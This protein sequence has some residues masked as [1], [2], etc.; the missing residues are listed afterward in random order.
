MSLYPRAFFWACRISWR[1]FQGVLWLKYP[2]K[3]E[4]IQGHLGKTQE[5]SKGDVDPLQGQLCFIYE[6]Q[7]GAESVSGVAEM[8]IVRYFIVLFNLLFMSFSIRYVIVQSISIYCLPM[9]IIYCSRV[10]LTFGKWSVFRYLQ[11]KKY[12][13]NIHCPWYFLANLLRSQCDVTRIGGTIAK[14]QSPYEHISYIHISI[15]WFHKMGLP[16]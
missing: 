15:C 16:Q 7:K 1:N 10:F 8:I 9:I 2:K 11:E 3:A 4:V 5:K 14:C 6:A 13:H 12:S